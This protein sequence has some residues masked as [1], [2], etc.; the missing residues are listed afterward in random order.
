M[1]FHIYKV[2][3]N[4]IQLTPII[5]SSGLRRAVDTC[6]LPINFLCMKDPYSWHGCRE[7]ISQ[8]K[9]TGGKSALVLVVVRLDEF[10]TGKHHSHAPINDSWIIPQ[11]VQVWHSL[12]LE[13]VEHH[14]RCHITVVL[15]GVQAWRR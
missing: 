5:S 3:K 8:A 10:V 15:Q 11:S 6:E 13:L 14:K 7:D 4:H 12:H 9:D 2:L 1:I